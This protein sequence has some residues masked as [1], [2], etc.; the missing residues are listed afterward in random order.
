MKTRLE[1][2]TKEI[3]RMEHLENEFI[4][5]VEDKRK[6]LIKLQSLFQQEVKALQAAA[7]KAQ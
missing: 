1:Y 7:A 6:T 3:D 4:G 5:K 2:I